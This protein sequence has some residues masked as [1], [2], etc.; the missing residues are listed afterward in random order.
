MA[1]LKQI[2]DWQAVVAESSAQRVPILVMVDQE[3]CPFC[4]RV[5]HEFLAALMANEDWREKA[6]YGK[7]SIDYGETIVNGDGKTVATREFLKDYQPDFTP[8]IL[9]LDAA[10]NPLADPIIG[11]STPDYYGYY[12]EQGLVQAIDRLAGAS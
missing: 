1:Q 10:L 5:E 9:Y 12:L 11:L 4:H 2:K 6:I 8:T 3:D 7:I